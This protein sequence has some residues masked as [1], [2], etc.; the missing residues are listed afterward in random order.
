M[1]VKEQGHYV[2]SVRWCQ[3]VSRMALKAVK[4]AKQKSSGHLYSAAAISTLH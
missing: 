4:K 1:E 3:R 2:R